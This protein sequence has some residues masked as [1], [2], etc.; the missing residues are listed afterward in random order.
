[1][2]QRI[3]KNQNKPSPFAA[4]MEDVQQPEMHCEFLTFAFG[5]FPTYDWPSSGIFVHAHL[6]HDEQV[7]EIEWQRPHSSA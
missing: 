2:N 3:L 6:S 5:A 7:H 4:L 1:M